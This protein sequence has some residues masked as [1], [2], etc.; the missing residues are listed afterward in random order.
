MEFVYSDG[1][2]KD[3]GYKSSNSD[4]VTRAIAIAT[5]ISYQT[6]YDALSDLAQS[7]RRGKRKRGISSP[8]TGVYRQTY[9][10]YILSIG[11]RWYPT[12]GIGTGCTVHLSDGELPNGRLIVKVSRH[13]TTVID[14]VIY[15]THDPQRHTLITENYVTRVAHRCVY[16]YWSK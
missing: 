7:E 10:R 14:G 3:A 12:M 6:V 15:D 1:G 13:L 11:W 5:G 9:H 8:E 16:G 4:C 2:R